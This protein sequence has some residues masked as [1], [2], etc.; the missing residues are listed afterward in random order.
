MKQ[1]KRCLEIIEVNVVNKQDYRTWFMPIQFVSFNREQ[2]EL[3][4]SVPSNYFFE[5]LD[6]QFKKLMYS[7]VWKTFG[8]DIH[9][10]YRILTDSTN[11]IA[12]DV[13][14]TPTAVESQRL[15]KDGVFLPT[16]RSKIQPAELDSNLN[17]EYRFENFIEGESNK[18]PRSIGQ[19]IA[20]NPKQT[21]FNP[22]FIFGASGVGKTHLVNAIGTKL[23]ELHPKMRVLY[24]G[25][26]QFTVQYTDSIRNN[27]FNDFIN[28]YQ[29][30]DTLIV[31]DIQEL[32]GQEKTQLAFFHI[33]NHLK[34]NGKQIILT[35]DRD[36]ASMKGMEERLLTRFKWGLM[37]ELERPNQEL[38]RKILENKIRHD[39]LSIPE[40]VV[41]YIATN[42]NNSIRDLEGIVNSLMA[43]SVVYSRDIDLLMAEQIVKRAIKFQATPITIERIIEEACLHWGVTQEEVFS[44]SR[45]ANIVTV[46]Q[47]AMYL[48]QKHTKMTASRIGLLIGGRNHATVLHAI[49]QIRD[50]ISTDK[51]FAR[52]ITELETAL[53]RR[54]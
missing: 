44:K 40:D 53:K 28:F 36:P 14:T 54:K 19:A 45:K 31:D 38:C 51:E 25:A 32:A 29:T 7:V 24:V 3:L 8:K 43:S 23:K 22:L 18:L 35:S 33:F 1:W 13:D 4:L 6:G 21:T 16:G 27:S 34:M 50:R 10:M 42:V 41:E 5:I 15:S 2:K 20:E 48:A 9:I 52:H 17:A 47:T 12:T 49:G 26:H 30:I 46:R 11:N 37:A 39:G